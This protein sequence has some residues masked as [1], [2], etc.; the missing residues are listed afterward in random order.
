MVALAGVI[1]SFERPGISINPPEWRLSFVRAI[2]GLSQYVH[3]EL[4]TSERAIAAHKLHSGLS[5]P[6]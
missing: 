4:Q 3:H 1:E 2:L 6:F 5:L